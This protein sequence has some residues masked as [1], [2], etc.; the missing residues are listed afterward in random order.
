MANLEPQLDAGMLAREAVEQEK[1]KEKKED[2]KKD[3]SVDDVQEVFNFVKVVG[4]SKSADALWDI[5]SPEKEKAKSLQ[6]ALNKIF[7]PFQKMI[8]NKTLGD[9]GNFNNLSSIDELVD[10]DAIVSMGMDVEISYAKYKSM[11]ENG[12]VNGWNKIGSEWTAEEYITFLGK[13]KGLLQ[14]EKVTTDPTSGKINTI[15]LK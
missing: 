10:A 14:V 8:D 7:E 6:D 2:W 4:V 5:D 15:F 13:L 9:F 12:I 3:F 1:N 11:I